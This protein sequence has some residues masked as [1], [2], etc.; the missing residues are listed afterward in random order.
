MSAGSATQRKRGKG[1][2]SEPDETAPR[3]RSP[4]NSD[5]T[6]PRPPRTSSPSPIYYVAVVLLALGVGFLLGLSFFPSFVDSPRFPRSVEE[7]TKPESVAEAGSPSATAGAQKSDS[8]P[9]KKPGASAT[10]KNTVRLFTKE[11]LSQYDGS[12]DSKPI[13]LA[14]VGKVFDVS[15]GKKYYGKGG[16]YNFF[17]GRD[18]TRAF[19]SG[20]FTEEGLI[21][22]VT[23]LEGILG[24]EEWLS[25]YRKDYK[26]VGNLIGHF[27]DEN[28]S[29]TEHLRKYKEDIKIAKGKQLEEEEEKKIF[30]PCNSHWAQ[31]QGGSVWCSDER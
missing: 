20:N 16:G 1:Q 23:H 26:Y 17:A 6:A 27:Y 25:L 29:P 8:P 9:P 24:L 13:Y 5:E 7:T 4:G 10:R 3:P 31:G 11:E 15:K 2:L 18:G 14:I 21:E 30:P 22:D 28:G 12:D 19:I